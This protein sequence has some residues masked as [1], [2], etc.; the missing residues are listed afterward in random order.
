[1]LVLGA[2]ALSGWVLRG[3]CY[4]LLFVFVVLLHGAVTNAL[5]AEGWQPGSALIVAGAIVLGA[6]LL[7]IQLVEIAAEFRRDWRDRERAR[8]GLPAG[9]M[10]IIWRGG[11]KESDMPWVPLGGGLRAPYPPAARRLGVEGYAVVEFEIGADGV[12]KNLHCV[13]AWPTQMFYDASIRALR[14]TRFA[15]KPGTTP[16]F[17]M[18]YRMPFV[19]RIAGAAR[20]KDRGRRAKTLRPALKAAGEAVDKLRKSA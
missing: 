16:R 20:L 19:F 7:G 3:A 14:E 6:V 12:A 11:D 17:G 15:P 9:P 18:S 10:C 1:M 8:L 13:D 5:R 2:R 4:A